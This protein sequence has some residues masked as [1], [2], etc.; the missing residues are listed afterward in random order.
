MCRLIIQVTCR[1]DRRSHHITSRDCAP[2]AAAAGS[3]AAQLDGP[4]FSTRFHGQEDVKLTF[5]VSESGRMRQAAANYALKNC[6]ICNLLIA[7]RARTRDVDDS[8]SKRILRPQRSGPPS[9]PAPRRW[10]PGLA[11]ATSAIGSN[12]SRWRSPPQW[13][14]AAAVRTPAVVSCKGYIESFGADHAAPLS[15][16]IEKV[17]CSVWVLGCDLAGRICEIESSARFDCG[18]SIGFLLCQSVLPAAPGRN[19]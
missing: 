17:L 11:G 5:S 7:F 10:R 4:R 3:R 16:N 6:M 14:L 8:D 13:K 15:V 1:W 9:R 2:N 18:L 12:R 19:V